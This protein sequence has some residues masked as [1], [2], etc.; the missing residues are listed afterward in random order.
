ME[1]TSIRQPKNTS[2]ETRLLIVTISISAIVLLLLAQL[3]FS[4]TTTNEILNLYYQDGHGTIVGTV[5]PGSLAA[6]AGIISGDL[7]ID[8]GEI[9]APSPAQVKRLIDELSQGQHL[10]LTIQRN[11]RQKVVA[12][13]AP[14]SNDTATLP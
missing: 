8:A 2:R 4:E 3:R 10:L 9:Q 13:A 1:D 5:A 11:G 6:S 12:L 14:A 7:L